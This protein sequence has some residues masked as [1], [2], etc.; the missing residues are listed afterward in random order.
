MKSTKHQLLKSDFDFACEELRQHKKI[1]KQQQEQIDEL[2]RLNLWSARRL[3][4][5]RKHFAYDEL[6]KITGIVSERL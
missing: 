6:Y 5:S 4:K 1:V 3:D 2:V